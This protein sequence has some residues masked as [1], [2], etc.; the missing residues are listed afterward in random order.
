MESKAQKAAISEIERPRKMMIKASRSV[1]GEYKR[2]KV[3]NCLD[4]IQSLIE[5][6]KLKDKLEIIE[7][8][9]DTLM[10]EEKYSEAASFAKK[11]YGL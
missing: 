10:E 4:E 2:M 3:H 6:Y 11:K 1:D 8:V 9:Y 7:K 5:D